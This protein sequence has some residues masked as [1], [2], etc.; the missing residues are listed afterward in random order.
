MIVNITQDEREMN[1]HC[2][3]QQGCCSLVPLMCLR[4]IRPLCINDRVGYEG[5][6]EMM[7]YEILVS[8]SSRCIQTQT[9]RGSS[10][11][12]HFEGCL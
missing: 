8:Y 7:L 11:D 12:I 10:A 9:Y 2:S 4:F 1:E 5:I 3:L 6:F